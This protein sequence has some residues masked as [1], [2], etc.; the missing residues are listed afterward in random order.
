MPSHNRPAFG[1]FGDS[2]DEL[3]RSGVTVEPNMYEDALKAIEKTELFFSSKDELIEALA[4][5]NPKWVQFADR[6]WVELLAKH[7]TAIAKIG[8]IKDGPLIE[9]VWVGEIG[10]VVKIYFALMDDEEIGDY[11]GH[12]VGVLAYLRECVDGDGD[13]CALWDGVAPVVWRP[14]TQAEYD[15]FVPHPVEHLLC[16]FVL[17]TIPAN[18]LCIN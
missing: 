15:S 18:K 4:A 5:R 8:E 16:G 3:R 6:M 17:P 14:A 11:A 12:L 2:L 9:G 10:G 1:P 7:E 13:E